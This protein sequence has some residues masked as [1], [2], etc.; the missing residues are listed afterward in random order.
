MQEVGHL[1]PVVA[2]RTVVKKMRE[3]QREIYTRFG[4]GRWK[5]FLPIV[6]LPIWLLAIETIRKMC[7]TR[8]GLLG[9]IA[10]QFSSSADPP[11]GPEG[12][13]VEETF[14]TE[15]ALW[16]ENLLVPDPQLILPFMLSGVMFLN[17]S[18]AQRGANQTIW[19]RRLMNSLKVVAL[20]I[21]PLTLQIPSAMLVYWISSGLLAY[22][23]GAILDKIMP[24]KPP[25][26]PCKPKRHFQSRLPGLED[27]L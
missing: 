11:S 5:L 16:F 6:Q 14:A 8:T 21:G 27:K 1:G 17:L 2:Q 4:C 12:V 15:G 26:L 22:T 10:A 25:V 13:L 24:V 7:G 18:H 23:Q 19:Q 20:A 9:L 3:K